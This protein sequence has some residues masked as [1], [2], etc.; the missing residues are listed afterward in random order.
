MEP[1]NC[2]AWVHDDICEIWVPSQNIDGARRVARELPSSA[3]VVTLFPDSGER[4][5]SKLN[6]G[7]LR[8]KGLVE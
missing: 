6:R 1:Q 4:Y 7:W 2:T 5:L 8:E 3:L